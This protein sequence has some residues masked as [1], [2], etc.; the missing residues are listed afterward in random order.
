[1]WEETFSRLTKKSFH[2]FTPIFIGCAWGT[3]EK[4][5][6]VVAFLAATAAPGIR[7]HILWEESPLQQ[8]S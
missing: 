7:S 3:S 5:Y 1:M 6:V 2:D 8:Q 4:N